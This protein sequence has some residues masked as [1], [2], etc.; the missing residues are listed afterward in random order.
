M[1]DHRPKILLIDNYDSFTF[2]L[3]QFLGELGAD[4]VVRRNDALSCADALAMG[5]AA[6]VLSPG[7]C[8]PDAAGI[9]LALVQA[10]SQGAVPLLGVCLGHQS[11][12]Q[13]FGGRI[14]HC[15]E[16]VHGKTGQIHH[17]GSVP[18][19]GLP[20]PFTATRYH[21]LAVERESL[22]D[23]LEIT[24]WTDDGVI[25]GLKHKE[26]PV[27]GVQF[28]PESIATVHGHNILSQFLKVTVDET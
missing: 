3:V 6:I 18:M 15:H 14:V 20:S 8:R 9:C 23:E 4:T 7:P 2:N 11:I 16:I 24:A 12:G 5:P 1:R 26:L 27:F 21:S 10:A 22:P 17:N 19:Q 13:A 28:H 25:M